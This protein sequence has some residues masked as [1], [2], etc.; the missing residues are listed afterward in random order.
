VDAWLGEL[1][2][3]AKASGADGY[4]FKD[5]AISA[6]VVGA[7]AYD[8][9][10]P[11]RV[12][13]SLDRLHELAGEKPPEVVAEELVNLEVYILKTK[14]PQIA[15]NQHRLVMEEIQKLAQAFPNNA[16]LCG[17]VA[18]LHALIR[19]RLQDPAFSSVDRTKFLEDLAALAP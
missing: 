1:E 19:T 18:S 16:P 2:A 12:A 7:A 15:L 6:S 17:Q 4:Y 10:D 9:K 3:L 8:R 14:P 5:L 13:R 11:T